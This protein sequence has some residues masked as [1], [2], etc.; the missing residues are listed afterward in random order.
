MEFKTHELPKDTNI[1]KKYF[2]LRDYCRK[3]TKR[4]L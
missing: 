4:K 1:V 3:C 2:I